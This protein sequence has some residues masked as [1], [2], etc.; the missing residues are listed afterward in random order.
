MACTTPSSVLLTSPASVA[1]VKQEV[2]SGCYDAI[3][4]E[5]DAQRLQAL[6]DPDTLAKLDLIQVI[7][8]GQLAL[9]TAN[10]ALA[11]YQRRLAKQLGIEPGA[12][13]KTAVTMA[14]ERDLP[15]I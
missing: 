11:A 1:A 15:S 5:L 2:E 12:E 7:R 9:F 4:V 6:C 13:L 14:R 10:L 8:K 3:A